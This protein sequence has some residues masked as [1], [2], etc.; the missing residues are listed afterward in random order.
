MFKY[1]KNFQ[2][3]FKKW[4]EENPP[5]NTEVYELKLVRSGNFRIASWLKNYPHQARGLMEAKKHGCYHKLS[6]QSQDK[7]PW[8]CF[9]IKNS[10]AFLVIYFNEYRKF[11]KLDIEDALS[12]TKKS[13]TTS[14]SKLL[15]IGSSYSL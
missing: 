3:K 7:K 1:E 9:F 15:K 6:D 11:I 13:K 12:L 14:F 10:K 4:I 8:D 5:K 2:I